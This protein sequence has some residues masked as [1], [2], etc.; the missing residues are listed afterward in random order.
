[1]IENFNFATQVFSENV[2]PLIATS[3]Y[4]SNLDE[5]TDAIAYSVFKEK[6]GA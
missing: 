2:I 1:M 5:G 3:K 6:L 4:C